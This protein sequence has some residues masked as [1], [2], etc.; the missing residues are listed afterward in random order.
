MSSSEATLAAVDSL[1]EFNNQSML[2]EDINL[3][4][5]DEEKLLA[6]SS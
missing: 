1:F 2:T 3:Y 5:T 6:T 4:E